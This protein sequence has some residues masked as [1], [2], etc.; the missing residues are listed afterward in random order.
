MKTKKI[1]K[2][3]LIVVLSGVLESII[4]LEGIPWW[5][6]P[7]LLISVLLLFFVLF[8]LTEEDE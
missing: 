3:I 1:L 4:I 8:F 7:L 6:F 2:F 5:V